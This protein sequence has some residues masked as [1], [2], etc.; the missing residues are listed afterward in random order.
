MEADDSSIGST[1]IEICFL[2]LFRIS[3]GIVTEQAIL[4]PVVSAHAALALYVRPEDVTYAVWTC[5]KPVANGWPRNL[6]AGPS[7][8]YHTTSS[9]VMIAHKGV[10]AMLCN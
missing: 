2:R 3:T 5:C 6:F 4:R 7:C 10:N 9:A 8:S 1:R